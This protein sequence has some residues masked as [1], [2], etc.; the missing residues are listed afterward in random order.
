MGA[1]RFPKALIKIYAIVNLLN[2]S[3]SLDKSATQ[4]PVPR[5]CRPDGPQHHPGQR[6]GV[7]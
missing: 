6:D 5:I 4:P 2:K 1:L 3:P 7:L